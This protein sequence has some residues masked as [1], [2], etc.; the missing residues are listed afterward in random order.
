MARYIPSGK[1]VEARK[2]ARRVDV[3]GILWLVYEL[4][5]LPLDRRSSPS[6]VFESDAAIRLVRN[7]PTDWRTLSD[8]A[9]YQ[10]SWTV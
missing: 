8:V 1:V 4:P 9:L 2:L 5:P 10:L 6:L 7:Y 3:A